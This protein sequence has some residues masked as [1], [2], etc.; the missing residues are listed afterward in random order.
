MRQ[1]RFQAV[2]KH[3]N[4]RERQVLFRRIG[5]KPLSAAGGDDQRHVSRHCDSG[6]NSDCGNLDAR[7]K[8]AKG[9]AASAPQRIPRR[10]PIR[11]DCLSTSVYFAFRGLELVAGDPF[12]RPEIIAFPVF[13]G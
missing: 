11:A 8:L 2:A 4:A 1:E 7:P 10:R 5:A 9:S 13:P 12:W 3:G 6:E